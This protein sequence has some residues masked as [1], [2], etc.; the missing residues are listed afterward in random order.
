MILFKFWLLFI[1]SFANAN[2]FRSSYIEFQYPD[3]WRCNQDQKLWIC[4]PASEASKS[5]SL[6][7]ILA[8]KDSLRR[9]EEEMKIQLSAPIETQDGA[10]N[11]A[12]S[13]VVKNLSNFSVHG[14]KWQSVLHL[15]SE[16]P[17]FYTQY[18]FASKN[19]LYILL[20]LTYETSLFE[21]MRLVSTTLQNS[22]NIIAANNILEPP[23]VS[24]ETGS[25]PVE[26]FDPSGASNHYASGSSKRIRI[27][28]GF[29][30]AFA[31]GGAIYLKLR[32][33]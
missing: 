24:V 33:S 9:S 2:T 26:V 21:S 25:S 3:D 19:D 10:G 30:L 16:M 28:I 27:F 15:N 1:A 29:I 14:Q 18:L 20:S 6:L 11:K 31:L 12:M 17:G 7:A 32:K 23:K 22:L 8:K 5:R 4:R 13:T